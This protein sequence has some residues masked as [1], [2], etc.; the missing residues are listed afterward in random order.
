MMNSKHSDYS[1]QSK[2]FDSFHEKVQRWIWSKGWKALYDIQEEST[3]IIMK[4]ED[5][6]IISAT[7]AGGKTEAVFFPVVS[8]LAFEIDKN[9]PK[10]LDGFKIRHNCQYLTVYRPKKKLMCY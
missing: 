6:L 4:G 10:S 2:A 8:K 9:P 3:P 1:S 7:T 5:D